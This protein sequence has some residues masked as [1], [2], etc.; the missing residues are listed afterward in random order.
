M[1]LVVSLAMIGAAGSSFSPYVDEKGNISLPKD[2]RE[3]W[4]Y[5]GSYIVPSE[6]APGYGIRV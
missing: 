5:L 1:I 3:K 6:K 2:Y 4:V